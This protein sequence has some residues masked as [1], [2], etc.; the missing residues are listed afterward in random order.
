MTLLNFYFRV[1]S[2]GSDGY[3]TEVVSQL[4]QDAINDELSLDCNNRT[5]YISERYL[6]KL[7][8]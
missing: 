1:W 6:V 3:N 7:N 4:L 2:E 8:Y 5:S